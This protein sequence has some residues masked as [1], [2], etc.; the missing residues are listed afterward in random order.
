MRA[1]KRAGVLRLPLVLATA[2]CALAACGGGGSSTPDAD[3]SVPAEAC[4]P[5]TQLVDSTGGR[6]IGDGTAA[7]CTEAALDAVLS[8]G[9]VIYFDCGPDPVTIT[10]TAEKDITANTIIDGG[11]KVTLDGGG[12]HRIFSINTALDQATPILTV[13]RLTFANG[14]GPPIDGG[15]GAIR[16]KGGTLIVNQC[17][18][19]GNHGT[20]A[21]PDVAGGA[22][23]SQGMSTT[24]VVGSLFVANSASNGGALGN[25]GNSLRIFNSRFEGN[26]ATGPGGMPSQGGN[27]GAVSVTGTMAALEICGSSFVANKGHAN[28]GA[29]Y[30][31]ATAA[32]PT[33]I[34][35]STFKDNKLG[36]VDPSLGGALYLE[37]SAVTLSTSAIVGN[38]ARSGGGLY[39]S[40]GM[41]ALESTTFADN[42][43]SGPL[44]GGAMDLGT[45]AG[46]ITHATIAKNRASDGAALVGGVAGELS[47]VTLTNSIIANNEVGASA[48]P[49]NCLGAFADGGGNLQF[50]IMHGDVA[51]QVCAAAVKLEDPLLGEL[52][53]AIYEGGSDTTWVMTPKMGSPALSGGATN[54]GATDQ[55][56]KTRPLPCTLGAVEP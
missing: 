13:Q 20:P 48:Q 35:R 14:A 56:G 4:P 53:M 49:L 55:R 33:T 12:L 30:H 46:T 6:K 27:G 2:A 1:M 17:T 32:E 36:D 41:L 18:F 44:G 21:G 50:P 7:S 19:R 16:R 3:I 9:G 10:T 15:G 26:E 23:S 42:T 52:T 40:T 24:L 29:V 28:G 39:M 22:I 31:L 25:I 47:T 54:C 37:G 43:A 5:P 11:G 38:R 45:S 34:T 51:D 8:M